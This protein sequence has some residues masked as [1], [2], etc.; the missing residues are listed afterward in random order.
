MEMCL[1]DD[2]AETLFIIQDTN[3]SLIYLKSDL[4]M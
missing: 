4:T 1:C 2:G 3:P